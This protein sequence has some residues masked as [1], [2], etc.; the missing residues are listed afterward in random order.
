MLICF[1]DHQRISSAA[2]AVDAHVRHVDVHLAQNRRDRSDGAGL[3]LIA[4]DQRVEV[5]REVH[6]DAVDLIDDDRAAAD[7]GGLN[8]HLFSAFPRQL[9]KRGVR[10]C[11]AQ[12]HRVEGIRHAR[13]VCLIVGVRNAQIVRLHAEQSRKQRAVRAVADAG[14]G[15]GTVQADVCA[16]HLFAEQ[17]S[18]HVADARRACCM[19]T[20]RADHHRPHHIENID[21][22]NPVL[23]G[24]LRKKHIIS[25]AE[26]RVKF[27]C[28]RCDY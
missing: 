11:I 23:S 28:P 7:R 15:K 21:H 25:A 2:V 10:V 12:L 18:A 8:G 3:V 14:L 13:A 26:K 19:R 17:R 1:N 16:R 27:P 9:Q 22:G 5:S 4:D 20:G 24:F 6:V